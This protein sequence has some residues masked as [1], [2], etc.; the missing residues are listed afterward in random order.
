MDPSPALAARNVPRYTSYPTAPH[1]SGAI[2]PDHYESWLA[3]LPADA[4]LSLYLHV[5]FCTEL[6]AYCGCNTKA[7]RKREPVEAYAGRLLE[8]IALVGGFSNHKVT[9]LHWGGGTPSILG[10]RWLEEIAE[11]LAGHFDLSSLREH[12]IEL[13]P[14]HLD[15]GLIRT[16]ASIG[17]TRASLGVQDV[18]PRIQHAIGRIQPFEMVELGVERLH[19]AGIENINIDLMYG[20]PG[21]TERDVVRSAAL[22]ASLNPQRIALFGY[23]HVPWFKPN[24]KLIGEAVLPGLAERLAQARDAADALNWLGYRSIGLDHFADPDDDLA[25]AAR[26]GRLR[27][28]FQGYTTDSADALLG[29][30]ASAIGRLPQ[31]FVQNASDVAGYSRAIAAGRPAVVKGR[32]LAPDD[33][34][35]GEII[36]RLMC[37]L[38]V[39]VDAIAAKHGSAERFD[40]EFE[41]LAPLAE[42][43]LV[44]ISGRTISVTEEGRPFLRLAASAFDAYLA[45]SEAKHSKAV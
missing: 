43:G 22:A 25:V 11:S 16:L 6:C 17:V 2:G 34:L 3:E 14:R 35:R 28:N 24:Q 13:D 30:G 7:T 31:G 9:H 41:T 15:R 26:E 38:V 29:F 8:E 12:A 39:N 20:L 32:A 44:A 37:D 36:E 18:S 10:P 33:R 21:Q 27:R 42:E 19:A 45:A 5:P 4:T 40:A 1:F 23:A